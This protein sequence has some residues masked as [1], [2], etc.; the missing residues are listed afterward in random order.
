MRIISTLVLP[1]LVAACARHPAATSPVPAPPAPVAT[2][3]VAP[4]E[5][6]PPPPAFT[7]E[8]DSG[9]FCIVRRGRLEPVW[10]HFSFKG[11]TVW[12]G[13]PIAQAFPTDSTYALNAA[14]YGNSE[15]ILVAGGLY[16]KYGLPRILTP[17]DVV[18]VAA[19]RGVPVFA[20]PVANPRRPEIFY[21]PV[22]PG[23]EFQ[24]YVP[25]AKM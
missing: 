6:P 10:V 9:L 15:P 8:P 17:A 20:E 4:A 18:P 5:A 23:C 3:P 1:L 12:R 21:V 7:P 25:L 2:P 13:T 16:T 19:F 22:R 24:P 11:D 14:W